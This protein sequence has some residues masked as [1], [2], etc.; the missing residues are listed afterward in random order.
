MRYP[1]W[2][3]C[4]GCARAFHAGDSFL[5]FLLERA[6]GRDRKS[7]VIILFQRVCI[8]QVNKSRYIPKMHFSRQI[9]QSHSTSSLLA[10]LLLRVAR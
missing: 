5:R 3:G 1:G 4:G 2:S 8:A 9:S 7:D 6:T 10:A